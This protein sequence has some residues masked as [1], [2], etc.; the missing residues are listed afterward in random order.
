M[1]ME[2]E[3]LL[4]MKQ[5]DCKQRFHY[6]MTWG[7]TDS[8]TRRLSQRLQSWLSVSSEIKME[9]FEDERVFIKK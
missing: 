1:I 3:S 2:T 9:I 6:T 5:T 8:F 4:L 7:E